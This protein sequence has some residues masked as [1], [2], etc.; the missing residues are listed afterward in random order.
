MVEEGIPAEVIDAAA[1]DFGMPMGPIELV[2]TVG[3][4]VA[5]AVGSELARPGV[6]EPQRIQQLVAA[7]K[8]GKKSGEGFYKWVKGKP[9]KAQGSGSVDLAPLWMRM[10]LP[11]VN[12]A[13]ACVREGIVADADLC[14]A[15]VIFGTGFAPHR[16]GPLHYLHSAGKDRLRAEMKSLEA[17]HGARF[18]A[19]AGWDAI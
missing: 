2:D 11:A 8:L 5:M 10:T 3:L 17:T 18:E 15:G 7:K 12:E 14:D 16:G 19:D 9:Q 13:V 6:P 1:R 4:D